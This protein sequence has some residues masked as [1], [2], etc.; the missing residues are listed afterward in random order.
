[1][2]VNAIIDAL[3]NI[4]MSQVQAFKEPSLPWY[5]DQVL[6]FDITIAGSN[7]YGASTA[8]KIFG[9]EILSSGGGNSIDDAVNEQE[10]KF[11]A[12]S[13]EP[14]TAQANQFT[15]TVGRR[16]RSLSCRPTH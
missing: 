12:R 11:V 1:M 15:G 16:T 9:V 6:P 10:C 14:W 8:M 5:S 13:I 2:P 3:D 4:P 7:E